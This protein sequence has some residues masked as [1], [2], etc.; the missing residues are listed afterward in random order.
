MIFLCISLFLYSLLF[1]YYYIIIWTDVHDT[2]DKYIIIYM[3]CIIY[4]YILSPRLSPWLITSYC[5]NIASL[6]IIL[7]ILLHC[8]LYLYS[9]VY[10]HFAND[11]IIHVL[12]ILE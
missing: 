10:M 4:I 1:H 9:Q 8:S 12:C 2:I 7:Y 6:D 3:Q 5:L 11:H